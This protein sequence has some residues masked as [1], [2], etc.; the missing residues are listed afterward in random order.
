[1]V[2]VC[3]CVRVKLLQWYPTLSSYQLIEGLLHARYLT[4]YD[5]QSYRREN[6]AHFKCGN[7]GSVRGI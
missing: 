5:C 2:C 1:M 3:V 4:S 6:S 7:Q